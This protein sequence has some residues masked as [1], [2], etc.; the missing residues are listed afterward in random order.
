[1][2]EFRTQICALSQSSGEL[3]QRGSALV[4]NTIGWRD[5]SLLLAPAELATSFIGF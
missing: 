1:M 3:V 5:M 4:G 2:H